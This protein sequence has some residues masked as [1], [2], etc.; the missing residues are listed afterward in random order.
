MTT[1]AVAFGLALV[2][3]SAVQGVVTLTAAFASS[4]CRVE[5]CPNSWRPTRLLRG[6]IVGVGRNCQRAGLLGEHGLISIAAAAKHL[7]QTAGTLRTTLAVGSLIDR[8]CEGRIVTLSLVL[9]AG[10]VPIIRLHGLGKVGAIRGVRRL[11][12]AAV[13][14]L[15]LPAVSVCRDAPGDAG[16]A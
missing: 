15:G 12:A 2:A 13:S 16:S 3:T 6:S 11:L 8:I 14:A 4:G 10:V 5:P 9:L 7:P 1:I